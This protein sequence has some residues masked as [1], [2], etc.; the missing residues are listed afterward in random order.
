MSS[1]V[2]EKN[3]LTFRLE[4][5]TIVIEPFGKN[6]FRVRQ[7]MLPALPN[8]DC[9]LIPQKNVVT[10]TVIN[11]TSATISN[12]D[13]QASLDAWGN[14]SFKRISNLPSDVQLLSEF[15]KHF[16]TTTGDVSEIIL[17]FKAHDEERFFGL[18][19]HAHGMLDQKGC[20]IDLR[21]VNTQ[22]A[23]P[24]LISN[25]GYGFIWHDPSTGRVELGRN[26]TRWVADASRGIDYVVFAGDTYADLMN[27]YAK[28]TGMPTVLP[29]WAAGFWQCK[30]RYRNQ[31]E[32]LTVAREYKK[33]NLPLSV[34]V[35]DFFHWTMLG[36]FK[37]DSKHW[38]DP[39]AMVDELK[40]MGVEL[41][42]SIWP[43]VNHNS[44]NYPEMKKQ[45][46]L[47]RCERGVSAQHEFIDTYPDGKVFSQYYDATNPKTMKF[48]WDAVKKNYYDYGIRVFWL[49]NCEPDIQPADFENIRFHL[50]NGKEVACIYPLLNEKGF[51]EGLE[52]VGEKEIVTLC[53]SG[54]LGS[55][56]FGSIIWS[57]DI[58]ST[59]ESLH[60]QIRAGLNM[61][62]SG[63]PWWTT[64]IG[65]FHNG[66]PKEPEF[67]ELIIRWFQ[68]GVFCPIFRLHG[69]REPANF[70][71]VPD[72]T[73]VENEVWSFGEKA[74]EI[75]TKLM[76][77]RE[78]IMP[79]IMAQMDYATKTG[80]P[81][82]RPLFFD[83]Q[84]D[85][86]TYDWEDEFLFGPDILVA[87]V[88][89]LGAR[90][91]E[92]YLPIGCLWRNAWT[93]EVVNGGSVINAEA[94]LERIP[95]FLKEGSLL[96]L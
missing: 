70:T 87:P 74:Y 62:M 37:F 91:R 29:K 72:L 44:E 58:Q 64:D 57:G 31:E 86:Q 14:V 19:Q 9:A 84:N 68:Y 10:K 94:P 21:Q 82:M 60:D 54:W 76:E 96:M 3:S 1:F 34:I 50:G 63:I 5:L 48:V 16:A 55:Q 32:L 35:I 88:A 6:A 2:S 75:I 23:I 18:G 33:R 83:F 17:D 11:E 61:A 71:S 41:V 95:V 78:K 20:I 90:S 47:V 28:I 26:R 24:V 93:D 36:D 40:S 77:L 89:K 15:H 85:P 51:Y 12:T 92:V 79:Y 30:L 45:G 80:L 46:M 69:V 13:L 4:N 53:R 67:Q 73:G 39:K 66:N 65:G 56:K 43:M 8:R 52:S 42:V 22:I 7:S 81:P 59:F 25:R 27:S 38:P 49:D